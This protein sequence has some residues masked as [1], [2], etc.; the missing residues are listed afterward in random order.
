MLGTLLAGLVLGYLRQ[1]LLALGVTSDVVPVVV[2]GLLIAIVAAKL[3]TADLTLK[4]RNRRTY[5]ILKAVESMPAREG[6]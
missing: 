1:G 4:R 3:L 2:G 5:R 6:S